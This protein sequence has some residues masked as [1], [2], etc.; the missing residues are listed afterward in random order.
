[1]RIWSGECSHKPWLDLKLQF[2][3]IITGHPPSITMACLVR[4][5][6]QATLV[7]IR[8]LSYV[9]TVLFHLKVKVLTPTSTNE[10]ASHCRYSGNQ[11]NGC[12]CFDVPHKLLLCF[13]LTVRSW[14]TDPWT[15]FKNILKHLF[16]IS[17]NSFN[18]GLLWF[19]FSAVHTVK[20]NS[21][22]TTCLYLKRLK[23]QEKNIL[24]L[25]AT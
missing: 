23:W 21:T 4:W 14:A 6:D 13:H 9:Y 15:P 20:P 22:V 5:W 18:L 19:I 8:S 24:F 10:W 25:L 16:L 2:C 11:K 12:E 17:L 7:A 1:M 3:L